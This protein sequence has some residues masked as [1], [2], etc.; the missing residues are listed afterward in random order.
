[1]EVQE[2]LD[3]LMKAAK[4]DAHFRKELKDTRLDPNP[5]TAFCRLSTEK[6]FPLGEMEL[7]TAGEEA[8]AAMKRSTN[9]GGENSPMLS[10]EDDY[11]GMFLAELDRL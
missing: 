5:L 1:M 8:Y 4:K 2:I 6:G 9:G 10:G 7:L 3:E 11:Y